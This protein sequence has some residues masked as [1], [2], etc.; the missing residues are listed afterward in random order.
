MGRGKCE[1]TGGG[2]QLQPSTP[3]PLLLLSSLHPL[4]SSPLLSSPLLPHTLS[5][6]LCVLHTVF[7]HKLFLPTFPSLF[8]FLSLYPSL[9]LSLFPTF[10]SLLLF[11]SSPSLPLSLSFSP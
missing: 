9:P 6:C 11:L 8:L 10:P 5:H 4:L 7:S 1:V 2:G 3:G